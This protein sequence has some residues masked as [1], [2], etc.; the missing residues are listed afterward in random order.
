MFS[1][2]NLK[3]QAKVK[4]CYKTVQ[5]S[6]IFDRSVDKHYWS[7]LSQRHLQTYWLS[8]HHPNNNSNQRSSAIMNSSNLVTCDMTGVFI[9]LYIFLGI[10]KVDR[11]YFCSNKPPAICFMTKEWIYTARTTTC[12]K[13]TSLPTAKRCS[14]TQSQLQRLQY[15]LSLEQH[16]NEPRRARLSYTSKHVDH[17]WNHS[18]EWLSIPQHP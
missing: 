17:T 14:P 16:S 18:K 11:I 15:R 12:N 7:D 10:L 4:F 3:N 5:S 9:C 8:I 2:T 6:A 13:I 1:F